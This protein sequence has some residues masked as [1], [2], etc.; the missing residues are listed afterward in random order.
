MNTTNGLIKT[1]NRSITM[2]ANMEARR[3]D[4]VAD[5]EEL[6][7]DIGEEIWEEELWREVLREE[8]LPLHEVVED[9]RREAD[10]GL[11]AM[12]MVS[13]VGMAVEVGDTVAAED[14]ATTTR[15]NTVKIMARAMDTEGKKWRKRILTRMNGKISPTM[16]V[17]LHRLT[18]DMDRAEE[19]EV[20]LRI[21]AVV[22]HSSQRQQGAVTERALIAVEEEEAQSKI[23]AEVEEGAV[24]Q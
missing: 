12:R 15:K 2:T 14:T 18:E 8:E 1:R 3:G 23:L 11:P 9:N 19:E 4:M 6:V 20:T 22:V 13:V 5:A 10:V 17:I 7:E 21:A 24:L 16:I